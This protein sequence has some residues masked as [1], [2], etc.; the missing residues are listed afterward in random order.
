VWKGLREEEEKEEERK[1]GNS[2]LPAAVG[3]SRMKVT[4]VRVETW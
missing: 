3:Q 2:G 4:A 1:D